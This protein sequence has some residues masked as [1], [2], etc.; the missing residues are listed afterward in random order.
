MEVNN[1]KVKLSYMRF[2]SV[3]NF[4]KLNLSFVFSG[5]LLY[6]EAIGYEEHPYGSIGEFASMIINLLMGASFSIAIIAIGYSGILFANAKGDPKALK[7]AQDGL[8]W[9]VVAA[10]ITLAAVVVKIIY[11]GLLGVPDSVG[12]VPEF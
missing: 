1:K 9:G 7:K 2:L 6:R 8:I 4:K 3:N 11:L 10:A 5:M 12:D